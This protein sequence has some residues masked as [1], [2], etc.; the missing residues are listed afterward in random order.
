MS[1]GTNSLALSILLY[2]KA[3]FS[4]PYVIV[5]RL[6]KSVVAFKATVTEVKRL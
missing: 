1:T 3:Y 4:V 5:P 2:H 6:E